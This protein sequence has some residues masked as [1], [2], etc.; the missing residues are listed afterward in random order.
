LIIN[1]TFCNFIHAISK[2]AIIVQRFAKGHGVM[3]RVNVAKAG[4]VLVSFGNSLGDE[5]L[6]MGASGFVR[7]AYW[8]KRDMDRGARTPGRV[9][10]DATY[11]NHRGRTTH[12]VSRHEAPV[13]EATPGSALVA[14]Q[15][16][17]IRIGCDEQ[18]RYGRSVLACFHLITS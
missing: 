9:C 14:R 7:L 11:K 17:L 6:S 13:G 18:A 16:S 2:L 10:G 15:S 12:P 3:I 5:P 8:Q 1:F 4:A